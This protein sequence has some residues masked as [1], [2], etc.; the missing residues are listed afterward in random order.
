MRCPHCNASQAS[1]RIP[2]IGFPNNYQCTVCGERWQVGYLH[3]RQEQQSFIHFIER[4][5]KF[6]A[7]MANMLKDERMRF[8]YVPDETTYK[9]KQIGYWS[10]Q[11]KEV[12]F[13]DRRIDHLQPLLND[14]IQILDP[15]MNPEIQK[16][17]Q[18]RLRKMTRKKPL[19]PPW[20]T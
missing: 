17:W 10:H 7:N 15:W 20:R 3:V 18:K 9:I 4:K 11:G 13:E 6:Q 16:R 14:K 2:G 8:N 19:V 12:T 5:F 1:Y